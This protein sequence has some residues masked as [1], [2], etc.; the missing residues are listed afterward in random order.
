M[1]V[2]H[3]MDRKRRLGKRKLALERLESR[4]MMTVEGQSFDLDRTLDTSDLFGAISGTIAWGDGSG[5]SATIQNPPVA[6]PIKFRFDYSL[7]NSGFF[8]DASRRNLLQT[9]A[10]MVAS[11][12]SD[13]LAAIQ[14]LAGDSWD[15]TFRHPVTGLQTSKTN[16]TIAA[17]EILVFVGGRSLGGSEGGSANRG[18][19]T[20]R[21][22]R[23]A[24]ADAVKGR[25]QAGALANPPTDV[26]PWGGS[27]AFDTSK[28]W[29]F[30]TN[31]NGLQSNQL[32]FVS[33]A[34]HELFHIMGFGTTTVWDNKIVNSSF[35]G[36]N[37][38]NVFGGPVPLADAEHF[39]NTTS[40]DGRRPSMVQ[41][42][43]TGERLLPSRLDLAGLQDIGWQL[44][45]QNVR[46]IGNH[47]YGDN[48]D[49]SVRVTL[50]G[51]LLG[52]KS[53]TSSLSV[54]NAPPVLSAIA[55][56]TAQAGVTLNLSGLGQF[57]DSGYGMP[58]ATPPKS[59]TF[60]YRVQ[61]GDGSDDS[62]GPA[63]VT[64]LGSPGQ[65]TSG[66]FDASHTY[67]N[68]GTYTAI[69]RVIDD[70]GGFAERTFQVVV[71]SAGRITLT[72][73]RTSIGENAGAGA[74]LMTVT[75]S[76]SS[77]AGPLV[78]SLTS[79]DTTEAVVPAV[80]TIP[81]NE[82]STTVSVSAVD[83]SLFDGTQRV[84][85][86]PS[87]SNFESI[88]V[89]L[90]VTD[91][92]P[93]VLTAIRTELD[94]GIAESSSTQATVSI[95]S[96]APM[97]GVAVSLSA[98]QAGI[99]VFPSSLTIPAGALQATFTVSV[100][101]NDRPSNPRT[102]ILTGTGNGLIVGSQTFLVRDNDPA[103]WTNPA[104]A[105]DVDNAGGVNPLDVLTLIDEINRSGARVLDPVLDALLLF[106][107]PNRD[108]ALDPLDVL[109]VIDQINRR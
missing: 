41:V 104:N 79:S 86:S 45:P 9:A 14:P 59:E 82:A 81:A 25:G 16:L 29:Y 52:S 76:G 48:A 8:F 71:N 17:N 38:I 107:D 35:A 108:G 46:V 106:V 5:S 96:P 34:A 24:F 68:P 57:S 91:F 43:G 37:A 69:A 7:D 12:F 62:T 74:A 20:A 93:L 98:S 31:A 99:L 11:K 1:F 72:L 70:D 13:T 19:F 60:T 94:E 66:F 80:V 109:F 84:T 40:I 49:L 4:S 18:G 3:A 63:T 58:L 92:Q 42:F 33:V 28:T 44:I 100:L 47:T 51:A 77:L 15:A 73:D 53:S 6:G 22:S 95:R 27:I 83:D 78:V 50:G 67:A 21:T 85:F 65:A 64:S 90:D 2:E 32:D 105:F 101:N 56:K 30:S 88:G 23:P 102:I 39:A 26:G 103:R 55:N 97:G 87:V 10:D 36:S 61:W 54:V 89:S 75:R